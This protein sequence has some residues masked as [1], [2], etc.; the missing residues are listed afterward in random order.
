MSAVKLAICVPTH[1]GR[2]QTLRELLE[3]IAR[4]CSAADQGKIEIC[5]SDNAS[6]DGTSELVR[7]F[8]AR[9]PIRLK[10]FRFER[11]MRGVRN[12]VKVVELADAEYCWLVGSDDM[13]PAGGIQ[14]VL[15]TLARLP[16]VAAMTFNKLNFDKTLS[17]FLGPDHDLV[18]PGNP[19]QS[20]ML[21]G[22]PEI[23]QNLALSFT[24]MSAHVFRRALWANVVEEVGIDKLCA[25]RHFP[26]SYIFLRMAGAQGHWYWLAEYCVIQRMDNFCILE[27]NNRHL[28]NYAEE[29]THDLEQVWDATLS[30]PVGKKPLMKRLF[31]LYW[32]PIAVFI[33]LA[34]PRITRSVQRS[35]RSEAVRR[36]RALPLFW[37]STY[38]M[39]CIPSVACR[40]MVSFLRGFDRVLPIRWI[41]AWSHAVLAG[42]LTRLR[43]GDRNAVGAKS[44]AN[45]YLDS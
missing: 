20:R 12:F 36:F 22:L 29:I 7:E 25:T 11:D 9:L 45:S 27:E 38:P 37:A 19:S 15:S 10:Y 28:A 43:S 31:F 24:F 39:L 32:N 17:K 30:G 18:L 23:A 16:G 33:Y 21:Q 3:S 2:A 42:M 34:D 5:V 14:K 4:Q 35:M 6:V 26:H 1:E 40:G 44:A 41:W 13:I 8:R